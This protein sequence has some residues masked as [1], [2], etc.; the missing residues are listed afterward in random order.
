V[1][2]LSLTGRTFVFGNRTLGVR[3]YLAEIFNTLNFIQARKT[4]VRQEI[5]ALT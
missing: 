1:E 2:L 3:S 4:V 5:P